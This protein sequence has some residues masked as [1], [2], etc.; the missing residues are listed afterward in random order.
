MI[1]G[2]LRFGVEQ[3][4]ASRMSCGIAIF[5]ST[6]HPVACIATDTTTDM[7]SVSWEERL[8]GESRLWQDGQR[9]SGLCS[10]NFRFGRCR[11]KY[12][13]GWVRRMGSSYRR[14]WQGRY[15]LVVGLERQ[16]YIYTDSG[17]LGERYMSWNSEVFTEGV[18][19]Q[20]R[21]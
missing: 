20:C 4:V 7:F 11:R 9:R 8:C 18:D 12:V 15:E 2:S 1:G 5:T 6:L 13:A 21:I 19:S 16:I 10:R 17:E 14:R 3:R